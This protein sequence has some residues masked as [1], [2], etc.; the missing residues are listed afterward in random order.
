MVD[1]KAALVHAWLTKAQS[2]LG[3]AI[4]LAKGPDAY[5]DTAIYHCQ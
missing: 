2:D 5:L 1:P 3:T 4:K